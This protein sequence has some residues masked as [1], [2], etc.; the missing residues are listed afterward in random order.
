M[1]NIRDTLN[2][3]TEMSRGTTS[4]RG[5]QRCLSGVLDRTGFDRVVEP[6]RRELKKIPYV[7]YGIPKY[8][9]YILNNYSISISFFLLFLYMY[10]ICLYY[11]YMYPHNLLHLI[12]FAYLAAHKIL[13]VKL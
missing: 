13:Y 10:K 12:F 6:E 5:Q 4:R 7:A 2:K 1:I 11:Y 3:L 8:Q 9:V